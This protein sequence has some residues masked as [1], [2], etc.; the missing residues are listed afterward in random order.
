[1]ICTTQQYDDLLNEIDVTNPINDS[2]ERLGLEA[3]NNA[4]IAKIYD[5]TKQDLELILQN[6]PIVDTKLKELTL[7]EFDN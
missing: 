7:N 5:L 4:L 6:F 3:Q 2:K 1:M